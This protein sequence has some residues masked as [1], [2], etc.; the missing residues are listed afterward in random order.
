MAFEH[1]ASKIVPG[2]IAAG[3]YGP[4]P[5]LGTSF[6]TPRGWLDLFGAQPKGHASGLGTSAD[7]FQAAGGQAYSSMGFVRCKKST[8]VKHCE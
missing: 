2:L 3:Q 1:V 6:A 5:L 8:F 7:A 4:L